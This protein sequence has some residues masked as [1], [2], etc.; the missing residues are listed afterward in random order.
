LLSWEADVEI[1]ALRAQGWTI[2]A[3]AR[4][5]NADRKTVR[6]Y[7][8]GTRVPGV[9]QRNVPDEFAPFVEYC[10]VRL[11]DDPHL[12]AVTLYDEVGELGYPGGY[13]TFT[14]AVRELKLRPHCEP[15]AAAKGRDHAIIAHP[16]GEETQWDWLELPDPPAGWDVGTQAHLLVGALSHS[17]KWRGVLADAE[18]LPHLVEAID[19]VVRRLGGL[20][21]RWRFDRMATVC[22]PTSGRLT[23]SFAAVAKY[24]AVAVDVCPPRHG[25]R[26]GVVEKANH[27]AAQRWWRTLPDGISV[28]AAQSG[29]DKRAALMDER[30]RTRDGVKVSVAELAAGERLRPPPP[31][32]Y[33]AELEVVRV[34][35]AQALV[36]LRGNQYSVPPGMSGTRVLVRHRLG[37]DHIQI[38]TAGGAVVAEHRRAPD[39]AGSVIR[40]THHVIALETAVLKAFS[41]GRPCKHKTRRPPSDAAQA[42]AARLRGMPEDDPAARVVIDLA[43]YA[44]VAARLNQA[45]PSTADGDANSKRDKKSHD[46]ERA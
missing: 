27:S 4:H 16:A 33:P 44:A 22:S 26:K 41:D 1:H 18:D 15:C 39:G 7:L 30:R 25:N 35:T 3:I 34:V 10:R 5:V 46:K 40:D 8:D 31:A 28:Q 21:R 17:G 42:E 12:W 29:L 9:R 23:A 32:P 13:S 37:A 14:R 2:S 6:A 19:A 38:A 45:T 24:Y 11:A 20:T 43:A 36:S